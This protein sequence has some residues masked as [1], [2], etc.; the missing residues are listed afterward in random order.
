VER[1]H[2]NSSQA[3]PNAAI[4][5]ISDPDESPKLH[6]AALVQVYGLTGAEARLC[7]LLFQGS[8]LAEACATLRIARNT[9]RAHLRSIFH[10]LGVRS[11][12]QLVGLLGRSAK[13]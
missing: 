3:L 11:Q 4:I 5:F 10:K 7:N 6:E 8:D 12:S 1:F 2:G 9:G 13:A